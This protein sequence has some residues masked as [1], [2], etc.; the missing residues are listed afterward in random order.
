MY[1]RSMKYVGYVLLMSLFLLHSLCAAPVD[2]DGVQTAAQNWIDGSVAFQQSMSRAGTT[3]SCKKIRSIRT[4][5]NHAAMAYHISLDPRGYIVVSADDR[6]YPVL[7][8]SLESDLNLSDVPEN[9]LRSWLFDDLDA[10]QL[11][12]SQL[13]QSPVLNALDEPAFVAE[14]QKAWSE[15]LD[16]RQFT[17]DPTNILVDVM[18]L[19]RWSQWNHYNEL[20]PVDP[21]PGSSYDGRVPV[22]CVA[23]VGAQLMKFFEW[24]PRGWGGHSYTDA[25]PTVTGAHAAVF[26]DPFDWD[27]M[28]TSYYAYGYV[29]LTQELAVSELMY[30]VGVSV[31]MDYGSYSNDGGSSASIN[32]LGS[33]LSTYFYYEPHNYYSRDPE[34]NVFYQYMRDAIFAGEPV[35]VSIP[36]H[37]IIADGLSS[38]AGTNY[39]HINYGWGGINDGWYLPSNVNGNGIYRG[40]FGSKPRFMPLMTEFDGSTNT[41][42]VVSN[43]WVFPD[44]RISEVVSYQL[45]QGQYCATNIMDIGESYTAW[46]Q[47]GAPWTN[48]STG[49]N[50]GYCYYKQNASS[51]SAGS[52]LSGLFIPATNTVFQFD[53]KA[54]LYTDHFYV[55][56][57]DDGG[58]TWDVLLHETDYPQG[59]TNGWWDASFSMSTYAGSECRI[60]FRYATG[61]YWNGAYGIYV[62]NISYS[63][64]EAL[65]WTVVDDAIPS[66]ATA[67]V[68]SN[69]TDGVYYY[70]LTAA[71]AAGLQDAGPLVSVTVMLPSDD[72]DSDGIPN[73]WE[74]QYFGSETGA[75]WDADADGDSFNN[76]QEWRTGNDPTNAASCFM[77][78][79]LTSSLVNVTLSWSSITNR[80][81]ALY[82]TTNLINAAFVCVQS[83]I[84]S[85]PS[86]NTFTDTNPPTFS[87][88]FYRIATE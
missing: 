50:P 8:F 29:P 19:T 55:E 59:Y 80:T 73:D 85:T 22:G 11:A 5:D 56:I 14:N 52:M 58:I 75:T 68:V 60:R 33:S 45:E 30:E 23:V 74:L 27:N 53:Y 49:G 36:G 15:I 12:L 63:N 34:T 13:D 81:Y 3:F 84:P 51:S 82:R 16:T 1:D 6:M 78:S 65:V 61:G 69:V 86:L 37:A 72:I 44:F 42:G 54:Q 4:A 43:E 25:E 18:L 31:E 9:A 20:C 88:L 10:C 76:W 38:D 40:I 35:I 41:S 70:K 71:N 77:L 67:Y 83:N 39:F 28:L 26:S 79:S 2:L 21:G 7:C 46:E 48:R 17:Y 57:T 66:N 32:D 24:P 62:D 47:Y 87:P 64:L